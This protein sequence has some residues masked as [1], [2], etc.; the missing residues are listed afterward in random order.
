MRLVFTGERHRYIHAQQSGTVAGPLSGTPLPMR[1]DGRFLVR[2][3]R[4]VA[5]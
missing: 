3:N 4:V 2:N 5:P 1:F